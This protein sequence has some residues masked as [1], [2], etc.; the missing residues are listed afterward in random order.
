MTWQQ[1]TYAGVLIFIVIGSGWLEF[2]VRTR[3]AR[4]WRRAA[5]ALIP[6]L[7]LFVAWDLY[8]IAEGHWTF[9]PAQTVGLVLPG[10]LPVEEL[11]F[12]LVVPIAGILTLEAVRSVKGWPAG[13]ELLADHHSDVPR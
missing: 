3:V 2:V 1:F 4:R 5:L 6:S 12:F 11:L 7:V 13:D 9:D 10:D 8:A